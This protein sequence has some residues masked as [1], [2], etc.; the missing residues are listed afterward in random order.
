MPA[1]KQSE[2]PAQ[3]VEVKVVKPGWVHRGVAMAV[4]ATAEVSEAQA[5]R[6]KKK[7]LV[8]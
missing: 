1:K 6:L 7:G 3:R 4:G 5:E 8:A 2:S